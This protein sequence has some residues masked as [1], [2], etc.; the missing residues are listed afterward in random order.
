MEWYPN[1][2]TIGI[3][4]TLTILCIVGLLR[5]LFRRLDLTQ[6]LLP[7]LLLLIPIADLTFG[8]T[9]KIRNEIKGKVVLNAIDDSFATTKSII[10][11]QKN[12]DLIG[13]FDYSAAGF[14]NVEKAHVQIINDST[15][16]FELMER[17]YSEQLTLDRQNLSL[18]SER[19]GLRYRVLDNEL[20]K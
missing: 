6:K 3:Y 1:I 7:A 18:K 17:E 11:R 8:W 4:L 20:L 19:Q 13:E 14:G 16:R 9:N 10:I 15:L 5:L 12:G 2:I